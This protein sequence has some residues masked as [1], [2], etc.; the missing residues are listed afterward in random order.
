MGK[1]R[2][3]FNWAVVL[4]V[5]ISLP[6]AMLLGKYS[7]DTWVSFMMWG[8]YFEYGAVPYDI[9]RIALAFP[10]G[11]LFAS[12]WQTLALALSFKI[13]LFFA[14]IIGDIVFISIIAYLAMVHKFTQ[15]NMLASFQGLGLVLATFF[16]GFYPHFSNALLLQ[17]WL[18]LLWATISGIFGA[19]LGFINK[20]IMFEK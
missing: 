6:F 1:A 18:A 11:G 4:T 7:L 15:E 13:P 9:K 16:T 12:L 3:P 19:I 20:T 14:E 8:V 17:P 2:I 10:W 5:I